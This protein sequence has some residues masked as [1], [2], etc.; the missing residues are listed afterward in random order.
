MVCPPN[1]ESLMQL[2]P[3]DVWSKCGRRGRIKESVGTHGKYHK[4][5]TSIQLIL[6]MPLL[7]CSLPILKELY[8]CYITWPVIVCGIQEQWSV[9]SMEF[10]SNTTQFAWAYTSVFIPNG[11][12]I[13]SLSLMLDA[14]YL[15]VCC[16]NQIEV[17]VDVSFWLTFYFLAY[18]VLY[19]ISQEGT[20]FIWL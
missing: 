4:T 6:D 1:V 2:Q 18:Y 13:S 12:S 8:C 19:Y 10:Y 3:V 16:V 17:L 7:T 11:L 5:K 14:W 20:I 15:I 9:F